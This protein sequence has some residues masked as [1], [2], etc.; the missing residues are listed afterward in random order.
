MFAHGFAVGPR[1][2]GSQ[3]AYGVVKLLDLGL[4]QYRTGWLG[5]Q[6]ID[7]RRKKIDVFSFHRG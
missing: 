4:P 1:Q 6:A 5:L 2:L 7:Q 3:G